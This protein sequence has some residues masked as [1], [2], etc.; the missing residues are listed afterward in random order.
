MSDSDDLM[1][2]T[3]LR[4]MGAITQEEMDRY[5]DWKTLRPEP[6]IIMEQP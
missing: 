1:I 4:S 3:A 5:L 2:M 6:H